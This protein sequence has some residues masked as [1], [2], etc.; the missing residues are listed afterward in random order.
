MTTLAAL[1]VFCALSSSLMVQFALGI[2]VFSGQEKSLRCL[3]IQMIILFLAPLVLWTAAAFLPYFSG[4]LFEC[5]LLLPASIF[6]CLALE[7]PAAKLFPRAMS[8]RFFPAATAYGGLVPLAA[9]V[10]WQTAAS[11]RD[12]L[13]LSFLFVVGVL[14]PILILIQIRRKAIIEKTPR[15]LRMQPVLIISLGL[16]SLV[17]TEAARLIYTLMGF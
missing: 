15:F 14:L 16:L 7:F 11:F 17:F 5:F 12:A 10:T 8:A 9:L 2:P 4:G 1:L 6:L 13:L 3:P